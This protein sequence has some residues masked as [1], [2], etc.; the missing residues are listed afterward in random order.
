MSHK[1]KLSK[2][3]EFETNPDALEAAGAEHHE[4]LRQ[5]L[6]EAE[7]RHKEKQQDDIEHIQREAAERATSLKE[8][9]KT[10]KSPAQK[11]ALFTRQQRDASFKRQMEAAQAD[12][13]P[14]E[15]RFSKIIHNKTVESV[16]DTVGSTLARPNALLSGS[17]FAF[18]LVTIV[19][20]LAKHY[21]Y[22]LSGFETI[23]A[24]IIGWILGF[25]YDYIKL[26]VSGK[27]RQ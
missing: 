21:G 25:I 4:R 20:L 11:R 26:L 10:E 1:E 13:T 14:S 12:M 19:Y 9:A 15:R 22:Q 5:N 8:V 18:L 27:K 24:F 6:E 16:S 23:G 7:A 3:P 17:I 2:T